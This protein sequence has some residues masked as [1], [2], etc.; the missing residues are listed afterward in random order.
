MREHQKQGAVQHQVQHR[1]QRTRGEN[2]PV[3]YSRR[4]Y[5]QSSFTGKRAYI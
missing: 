1:E 2:T 5:L 4:M 3:V